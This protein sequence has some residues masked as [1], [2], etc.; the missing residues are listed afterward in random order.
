MSEQVNEVESEESQPFTEQEKADGKALE[1]AMLKAAQERASDP[2]DMAAM[3]YQMYVPAYKQ[4]VSKLST[5]GMRR[6][7]NTLILYPYEMDDIKSANETEKQ[8]IGLCNYLIEAKFIMTM[9]AMNKGLE[10]LHEAAEK[11]LTA[12]E[13]A[14]VKKELGITNDSN[15]QGE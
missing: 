4:F 3:A 9:D 15:K 2:A 7:L 12:E 6:V 1:E 13:E 5:R 8:L 11:E 10:Q 14:E